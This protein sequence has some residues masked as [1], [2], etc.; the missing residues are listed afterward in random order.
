MDAEAAAYIERFEQLMRDGVAPPLHE[1]MGLK[2]VRVEPTT[3]LIMEM[4]EDVR[5]LAP[6]SVHGGMLAT[7]ADVAAAVSLW[8]SFDQDTQIPIT[9]D[10]HV[11]YFRQPTRGP[12]SAEATVVYR[13]TRLLSTEC[14]VSDDEN[15]LLA[16]ANATYMLAARPPGTS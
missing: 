1:R 4:G 9:T 5:G 14:S 3:V 13:G 12:L 2:L 11:R 10:L 7:F 8:R 15:R 6:G 16:R